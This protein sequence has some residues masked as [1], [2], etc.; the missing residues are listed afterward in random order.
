MQDADIMEP[1]RYPS[2]HRHSVNVVKFKIDDSIDEKSL[3][4]LLF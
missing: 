4:C 2:I 1:G 3:N